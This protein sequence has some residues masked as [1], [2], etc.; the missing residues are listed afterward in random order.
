VTARI[1]TLVKSLITF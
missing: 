1:I